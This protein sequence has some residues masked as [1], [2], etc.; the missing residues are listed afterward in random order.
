MLAGQRPG[1]DALAAQFGLTAKALVPLAGEPMLTHVVRTLNASPL[2][3]EV[4]VLAQDV[5]MLA[6]AIVSG[7]GARLVRSNDGISS[8]LIALADGGTAAYPWLVTTADNPLL[9][10]AMVAQFVGDARSDLAIGM[11]SRTNMLETYPHSARTWLKFADDGWSG[12]NLFMLRNDKVAS[13]L[14]MWA[15]AEKDRK[16]A[17]KLFWHFG[18]WLALLAITRRITMGQALEKAGKGLRLA[19]CLVAM[20][21][22]AAAIDVDKMS[23][24]AAAERILLQRG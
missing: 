23:D 15:A 14:A 7:G 5:E 20:A 12:A 2:I 24:H 19:A 10:G 13:A 3:G 16:Q 6:P 11:V 18:P 4:I 21:D 22:P 9:T 17:W 8:S 1:T